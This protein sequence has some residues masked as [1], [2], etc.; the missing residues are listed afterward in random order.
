MKKKDHENLS[1]ANIQKV[2]QL[3]E[4]QE[5]TKSPI[6][7]KDACTLLNISYNTTRLAKIIEE[8]KERQAYVAEQKAKRRGKAATD[9]EIQQAVEDYLSGENYSTIAKRLFRSSGFVKS[10]IDR[11]GVPQRPTGEAA[12]R[13]IDYLPERC[14]SESFREGEVV[15]AARYHRPAKVVKEVN[16]K[17]DYMGPVYSIYILEAVDDPGPWFGYVTKG[18]YYAYQPWYDLGKLEHL[19]KYG[20]NLERI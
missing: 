12:K 7:K 8:Y 20:V 14:V 6:T 2:I 5:T 18:G 13:G 16:S 17:G 15:W 4:P 10:I 19:E 3:L 9:F 11:V 1:D